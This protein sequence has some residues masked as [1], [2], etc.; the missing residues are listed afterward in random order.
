MRLAIVFAFCTSAAFSQQ[1]QFAE[2][3][4][5]KLASGEVIRECR[6]GY[7]TIGKLNDSRSNVV[8]IPTWANGTTEQ[9]KSNVGPGSLL[10]L[11][12]DYVILADALANGVSSSPSTSRL[13][14]HMHF[15]K[16]TIRDMVNAE[17][18]L[19]TKVLRIEH[20]KAVMCISMGA[21]QTFQWMVA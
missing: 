11:E 12:D 10:G 9:L 21:M 7:R 15:P 6:I 8:L 1:Q 20:V 13:Q 5:F 18:E 17:H 3:G 2:L 14:P 19:L 16:V 4:D